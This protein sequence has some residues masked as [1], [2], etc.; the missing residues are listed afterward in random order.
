[1]LGQRKH[2]CQGL[3]FAIS[4]FIG[5]ELKEQ[6]APWVS[7]M[8]LKN[9]RWILWPH[10]TIKGKGKE[11]VLPGVWFDIGLISPFSLT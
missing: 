8:S 6:N 1:M 10:P 11:G 7:E 4:A 5:T 9:V 2:V 3:P